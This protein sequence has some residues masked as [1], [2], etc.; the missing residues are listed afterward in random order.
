M[1]GA[2]EEQKTKMKTKFYDLKI[3][4]AQDKKGLYNKW[5]ILPIEVQDKIIDM[6]KEIDKKYIRDIIFLNHLTMKSFKNFIFQYK[7][8]NDDKLKSVPCI[9]YKFPTF[10]WIMINKEN[11]FKDF[12]TGHHNKNQI[13]CVNNYKRITKNKTPSLEDFILHRKKE[14]E[15]LS[16]KRKEANKNKDNNIPSDYAIGDLIS[17]K[18]KEANKTINGEWIFKEAY[19]IT[20]ETKT[21]YRVDK[22]LWTD[23][24]VQ[25]PG[26]RWDTYHWYA[27]PKDKSLW[28]RKKSKNIKKKDEITK[29]T[30]RVDNT[31]PFDKDEF[32]SSVYH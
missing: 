6:K 12:Y 7:N 28:T 17:A 9:N 25:T 18:K 16:A 13:Q 1:S 24:V 11:W 31:C 29:L 26:M 5:E 27:L 21:Q 19:I 32:Y 2:T 8:E 4:E 23:V 3:Q 10:I 14:K 20:G 15:E 22:L 30:G